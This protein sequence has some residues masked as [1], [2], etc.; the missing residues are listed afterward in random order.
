MWGRNTRN[1]EVQI[2]NQ[3]YVSWILQLMLQVMD[4]LM[5]C[6]VPVLPLYIQ[7]VDTFGNKRSNIDGIMV[8]M[9][10]NSVVLCKT[11]Q[12]VIK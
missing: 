8:L 4:M 7:Y 2:E 10:S 11:Y 12:S 1:H 3:T 9:L 6:Y 5:S